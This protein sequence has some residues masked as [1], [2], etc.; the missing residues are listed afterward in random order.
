MSNA[1]K[2]SAPAAIGI[3]AALATV[4][5][6]SANFVITRA[7]VIQNLTAYDLVALRYGTAGLLL[8]PFFGRAVFQSKGGIGWLRSTLLTLLAG[9]P[10]MLV[11]NAGLTLAPASHGAI[12]NPG[13]SPVVVALG[14]VLFLGMNWS[15]RRFAF[16]ALIVIG[17]ALL[18]SASFAVSRT[19]VMGDLMLLLTGLSWGIFTLLVRH[20]QLDPL[21]VTTAVSVISL[22]YLPLYLSLQYKG[23]PAVSTL[24]LA[25]QAVF[26][27][28]VISIGTLFLVA[29]AIR[30]I[31][32][33]YSSLFNP[34]VPIVTAIIAFIFLNERLG[35]A[36]W[37]GAALVV[38]GM[39]AA[40]HTLTNNA[41]AVDRAPK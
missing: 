29:L 40:A 36:Q 24:E 10:Y 9:A 5:L 34:L 39:L 19:I 17:L 11:F 23:F 35:V 27:G 33:S 3:G 18:T 1:P 28:V 22:L 30:N 12:L 14:S 20:W 26:H 2:L 32:P 21:K 13:F 25:F 4:F 37:I 15:T 41:A 31:G 16:L 8:L 38:L 6:Y 7:G